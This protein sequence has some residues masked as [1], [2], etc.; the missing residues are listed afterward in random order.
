METRGE[1]AQPKIIL[2]CTSQKLKDSLAKAAA[3]FEALGQVVE[4][5]RETLTPAPT[6]DTMDADQKTSAAE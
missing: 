2:R 3:A 1:H 6:C 4:Q 5:A